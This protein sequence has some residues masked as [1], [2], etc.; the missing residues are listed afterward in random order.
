MCAPGCALGEAVERSRLRGPRTV[1]RDH[2]L[3]I[4]S[5]RGSWRG[6]LGERA[7]VY[8][9][10]TAEVGQGT[11]LTKCVAL[12]RAYVPQWEARV[13]SLW[14][15]RRRCSSGGVEESIG[16]GER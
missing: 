7:S 2:G 6:A 5:P 15:Q 10:T 9:T 8:L 14:V 12:A 11:A 3:E 16:T 13:V 4:P 1:Q